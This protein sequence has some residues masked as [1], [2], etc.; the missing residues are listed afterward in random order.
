MQYS[1]FSRPAPR[2]RFLARPFMLACGIAAFVGW[3]GAP[4][5]AQEA[6]DSTAA[7]A[8]SASVADRDGE[9][10]GTATATPLASGGYLLVIEISGMPE[11]IH[12]SHLHE[13][14]ACEAPD[15]AS[16]GGHITGDHAHG[17][18]DEGGAHPGE[19]PNLHIPASGD[20]TVEYFAP[21]LTE[22]M[23]TDEDGAAFVIH[24]GPD[25]YASQPAGNSGDRI[26][27]GIFTPV[28]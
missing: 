22:A 26:A 15:F 18:M 24:A 14:G 2:A 11:G 17:V 1:P 4:G 10:R 13:T 12:A 7:Q 23:L 3:A 8:F 5:L 21:S 28:E 20:L 25:D 9:A 27:C 19:L 6:A 16:A